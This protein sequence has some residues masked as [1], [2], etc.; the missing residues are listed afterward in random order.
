MR[1]RSPP[2]RYTSTRSFLCR[3]GWMRSILVIEVVGGHVHRPARRLGGDLGLAAHQLVE[4][5]ADGGLQ[6][7]AVLPFESP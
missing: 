3:D 7:G 5:P 2:V 4:V 1:S 6:R